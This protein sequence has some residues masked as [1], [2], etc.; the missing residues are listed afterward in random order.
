VSAVLIDG[1]GRPHDSDAC[2]SN[3][4]GFVMRVIG[5]LFDG[6]TASDEDVVFW[7]ECEELEEEEEEDLESIVDMF[8][9]CLDLKLLDSLCLE[10][11]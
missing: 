3:A 8:V 7:K 10:T 5:P 11:R 1:P 9:L 2:L 4:Y 6:E